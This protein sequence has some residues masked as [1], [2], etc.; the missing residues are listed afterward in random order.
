MATLQGRVFAG[1]VALAATVLL[2]SIAGTPAQAQ[3]LITPLDH[4]SGF[5]TCQESKSFVAL[6]ELLC[7]DEGLFE[8]TPD[9]DDCERTCATVVKG[10]TNVTKADLKEDWTD[11]VPKIK[12]MLKMCKS[13]NDPR[14]CKELLSDAKK[15]FKI[16]VKSAQRD[17]K[18]SCKNTS[19]VQACEDVCNGVLVNDV[20]G[21]FDDFVDCNDFSDD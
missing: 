8:C 18:P 1:F 19:V 5:D 12:V 17:A 11:E 10:C 2:G 14:T 6:F 9:Q 16:D 20:P 15:S 13:T 21:V 7:G 4:D 3:N